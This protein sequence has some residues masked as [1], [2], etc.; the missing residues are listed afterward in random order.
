MDIVWKSIYEV[1]GIVRLMYG[2]G[3]MFICGGVLGLIGLIIGKITGQKNDGEYIALGGVAGWLLG[4]IVL[5]EVLMPP[6]IDAGQEMVIRKVMDELSP[7]RIEFI[8]ESKTVYTIL[9]DGEEYT[10]NVN[11]YGENIEGIYTGGKK[12]YTATDKNLDEF[13]SEGQREVLQKV[14]EITGNKDAKVYS[15]S[16]GSIQVLS[17]NTIYKGVLGED[18]LENI[19]KVEEYIYTNQ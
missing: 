14:R 17:G 7:E 2:V 13:V 15:E 8:D 18:G 19:T 11:P 9:V 6:H 1:S 5:I 4:L 16:W 12:V 10:V 3:I